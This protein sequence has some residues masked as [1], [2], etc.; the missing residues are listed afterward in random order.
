MCTV[1]TSAKVGALRR[2]PRVAVTIDTDGFPPRVLLVRGTAHLELVDGVPEEYVAA[3]KGLVPDE[4]FDEW[5]AGVR[6]LYEQMTRITVVPDWAKLLDFET[7]LPRSVE[8]L[9][10]AKPGWGAATGGSGPGPASAGRR[11]KVDAACDDAPGDLGQAQV[12]G[13]CVAAQPVE[14]GV[15]GEPGALGQHPLGLLDDD[16]AVQRGLQLLVDDL[17]ATDRPFLQDADRRHVGQRLAQRE[18]GVGSAPG[19]RWNRF[20][21]PMASRAAA[22]AARAP[23]GTPPAPRRRRRTGHR[24][25]ASVRSATRTWSAVR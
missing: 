18:I 23:S 19:S 14:R 7:T 11:R 17:A 12:L 24:S 22:A 6:A 25:A 16:P 9:I 3:S 1:P 20:S 8:D 10:R 5:E 2:N 21:A 4:Q 15:H 13:A